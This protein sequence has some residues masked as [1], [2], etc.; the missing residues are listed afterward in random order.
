MSEFDAR[1]QMRKE[2]IAAAAAMPE[3]LPSC[4]PFP[5]RLKAL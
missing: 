5:V 3:A 4:D 1:Q 2:N